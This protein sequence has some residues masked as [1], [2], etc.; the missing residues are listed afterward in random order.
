MRD[1]A[2]T[3]HDVTSC[4]GRTPVFGKC[5]RAIRFLV[6]GVVIG[7]GTVAGACALVTTV[8]VTA[9][10]IVNTALATNPH[11]YAYAPI[12]PAAIALAGRY[13][14]L[15]GAADFTGSVQASA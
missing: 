15:A 7:L 14:A 2:A 8:T 12:G 5:R 10:W 11:L 6:G 9:A 4:D 13:P 1:T 3:F